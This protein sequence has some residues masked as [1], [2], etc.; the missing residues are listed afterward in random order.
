MQQAILRRRRVQVVYHA[1][2]GEGRIETTL[3]PYR[4]WFAERAWYVVAHSSH[5]GEVRIFKIVRFRK[6]RVTERPFIL[7]DDFRIDSVIGAA[8]RMIPEGKV[9][10]VRIL[11]EPMVATNVSEVQWHPSQKLTWQDDGRLQFEA[12]VDG[13]SEISWWVLGYGD[14]ATVLGPAALR[15]RIVRAA[16]NMLQRYRPEGKPH[17][18]RR[19]ANP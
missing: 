3:S 8:W 7:P 4:L 12:D 18:R 5:H 19:A 11:F 17:A 1:L 14:Q 10:H 15:R 16:R 13:L 2:S 6:V 9:H